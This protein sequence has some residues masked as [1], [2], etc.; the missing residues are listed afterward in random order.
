MSGVKTMAT[1]IIAN[2]QYSKFDTEHVNSLFGYSASGFN[3]NVA[4]YDEH[5]WD[6]PI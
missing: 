5:I 2:G 4:P 6:L 3:V 1:L